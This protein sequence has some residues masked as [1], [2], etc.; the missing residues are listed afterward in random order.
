MIIQY[1]TKEGKQ[2]EQ[3][4]YP[5]DWDGALS[6]AY[7]HDKAE[8]CCQMFFFGWGKSCKIDDICVQEANPYAPKS[9][10]ISPTTPP[11]KALCK[12]A[13]NMWHPDKSSKSKCSNRL[14]KKCSH[15]LRIDHEDPHL[16]IL[17]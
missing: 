5:E 11:P 3:S 15:H 4:G 10:T 7:L 6:T 13:S 16:L 14:V 2:N 8:S 17:C 12:E 1:L 9:P